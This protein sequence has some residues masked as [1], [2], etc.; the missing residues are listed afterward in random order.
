MRPSWIFGSAVAALAIAAFAMAAGVGA[1]AAGKPAETPETLPGPTLLANDLLVLPGQDV[2]LAASLRETVSA[3]TTG[4]V[5]RLRGLE[6]KRLRFLYGQTLLGEVHTNSRGDAQ[7]RWKVPDKPGDY[8]LTVAIASQ[9]QPDKPIADAALVV[10]ARPKDVAILVV[11]LDKSL[12]AAGFSRVLAGDAKPVADSSAVLQRLA[13]K[14]TVVYL[15]DRSEFLGNL[16][17][18][19]L[20]ENGFPLGPV[21][22]FTAGDLPSDGLPMK[23]TRVAELRKTFANV[24]AV[25]S[26]KPSAAKAWADSGLRS[27]LMLQVDWTQKDPV[28]FEKAAADLAALPHAVQAVTDWQQVEAIFRKGESFPKADMEKRLRDAAKNLRGQAGSLP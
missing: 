18:R 11:G 26:D 7:V 1:P 12:V 19:W 25:I 16:G 21:M 6:G 5:S 20:A 3:T 22:A 24:A 14:H 15:A 4:S 23:N 13:E 27:V 28:A 10:A 8:A 2:V 9:D 17:R